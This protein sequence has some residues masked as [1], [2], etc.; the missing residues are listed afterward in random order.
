MDLLDEPTE[1][2]GLETL[3]RGDG[4]NDGAAGMFERGVGTEM[5]QQHEAPVAGEA[6]G[7]Q[8]GTPLP[9]FLLGRRAAAP[10]G[11]VERAGDE[12][13]YRFGAEAEAS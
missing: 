7:E 12:R 11:G 8:A 13:D 6:G 2:D 10:H 9:P 5:E 3:T 1:A 4:V